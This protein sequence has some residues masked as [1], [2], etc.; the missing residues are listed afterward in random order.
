MTM[1]LLLAQMDHAGTVLIKFLFEAYQLA[2]RARMFIYYGGTH[3]LVG[4]IVP[5]ME[6]TA[7]EFLTA[8]EVPA[9]RAK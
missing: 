5:I 7:I 1:P 2:P 6:Q 4:G 9:P 3:R 8:E